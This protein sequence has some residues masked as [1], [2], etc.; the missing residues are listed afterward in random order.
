MS[1]IISQSR[2]PAVRD[3]EPAEDTHPVR[4]PQQRH[5]PQSLDEI[6]IGIALTTKWMLITGRR[7]D[8]APLLHDLTADQL[9]D[10]WADDHSGGTIP[11]SSKQVRHAFPCCLRRAATQTSNPQPFW[12]TTKTPRHVRG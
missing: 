9:I 2:A 10:F 5:G 8:K 4:L 1:P 6:V 3:P 11:A 12:E 7:L